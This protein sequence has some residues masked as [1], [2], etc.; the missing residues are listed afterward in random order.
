MRIFIDIGHPAHVHYFKNFIRLMQLKGH[1]F[2]L[3]ARDKEVTFSLLK[4]LNIPFSSRGKGGKGYLGKIA[5]LIKGDAMVF[6]LAKK[7]KPDIIL[8]FGS[9]YAAHAA[10]LLHKPHIALDDTEAAKFGQFFYLPFTDI[11]LNPREFQKNF[12]KNQIRF[13]S[14]IELAGLH[15]RY[16]TPDKKI[17]D[18]LSIDLSRPY[19]FMR[20]VSW[21][22]NHDFNQSGIS[23]SEKLN[24]IS[25]LSEKFTILISA[26]GILPKELQKYRIKIAPEKIHHVLA[27]ATLFIG[28]GATMA[29]ECAMLGTPAIYINSITAGTL[30]EQERYGLLFGFRNSNGVIEKVFSLLNNRNLKEEFFTRRQKLLSD[31]IDI[32][33]F[34]VWFIENYPESKM[35]MKENPD[36]QYNF[37]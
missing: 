9:P 31:K 6:R 2:C 1:E 27:F 23:Y 7:F 8:S 11:K 3:S 37:K 4:N 10:F 16:F 18:E 5:Y 21:S 17:L 24:I 34:L 20:F 13:D 29:S 32:T 30:E 15:P 26:E 35:I 36:F 28:E 22:A 33:A 12:R 19:I 14:F 25:T